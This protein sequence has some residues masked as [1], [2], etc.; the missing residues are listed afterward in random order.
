MV[1]YRQHSQ[2]YKFLM[3]RAYSYLRFSTADQIHGDSL[4]RQTALARAW[5]LKTGITLVDNYRDL[6]IS[7]FRGKN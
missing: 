6:G 4:R 2:W 3:Q 7:A 5:C 1:I